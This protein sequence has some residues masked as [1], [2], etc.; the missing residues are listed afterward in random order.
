LENL[1]KIAAPIEDTYAEAFEGIFCRLMITAEDEETVRVAGIGAT[2]TPSVVIGRVE[3]GVERYLNKKETPDKR[4]GAILQF[5]GELNPN[6]S[7]PDTIKKFEAE[8]SYRIRQDILVKPFTAVFDELSKSEGKLDMME[9]VGHCGDGYEYIEK[10]FNKKVIVVPL[11]VPDFVIERHIGYAR[12][13]TGGNFWI[14]CATKEALKKSG[15]KALE[16]IHKIEGVVTPFDVCSAGSKPETHFP[17][18]GPTTNH[19]YCPSLKKKF[20]DAS[21]VPDGVNYIPEIVINGMSLDAVKK[22]MKAG[23]E[24]ARYVDGVVSISAG[25]YGGKLGKYNINLRELF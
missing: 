15:D 17:L 14:M 18:I 13:V 3:G 2:S 21:K 1:G 11:M 19:L 4:P 6:K 24:A 8:L 9:R 10:R 7:F 5:W 12:G 16:A 25:N 20:G 22:A 23:I